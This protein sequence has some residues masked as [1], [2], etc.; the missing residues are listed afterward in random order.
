[1]MTITPKVTQ[2]CDQ[3][4]DRETP[5]TPEQRALVETVAQAWTEDHPKM[6][7]II[8]N[9]TAGSGKTTTA[10][11]LYKVLQLLRKELNLKDTYKS[12]Q[13]LAFNAAARDNFLEKGMTK[14]TAKTINGLG[15][16]ALWSFAKSR[17]LRLELDKF[18]QNNLMKEVDRAQNEELPKDQKIFKHKIAPIRTFTR[19]LIQFAKYEAIFGQGVCRKELEKV[20]NHYGLHLVWT[21]ID[22]SRYNLTKDEALDLSYAWVIGCLNKTLEIPTEGV[23]KVDFNDQVYLPVAHDINCWKNHLIVVDEAQDLSVVNKKLITKCLQPRGVLLMI[24]D[25]RQAIY[26]WRGC[27]PNQLANALRKNPQTIETPL[28]V[29]WRSGEEI[30]ELAREFDPRI[31]C[32]RKSNAIVD[33]MI[34]DEFA[35]NTLETVEGTA[36]LSRTRAPL[37][38]HALDCLKF[39]IPFSFK[40]DLHDVKETVNHVSKEDLNMPLAE[41][42]KAFVSYTDQVVKECQEKDDET[43]IEAARDMLQIVMTIVERL[44]LS[45]PRTVADIF[46]EIKVIEGESRESGGICLTT[47]HSAK[48]LEWDHVYLLGYEKIGCY[49]KKDWQHEEA[50]NLKFVALTRAENHLTFLNE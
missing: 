45:A 5:P 29:N 27:R 9:S 24:G 3:V 33:D 8:G 42:C 41:F 47:I 4:F 39:G 17:G 26:C 23:W 46:E 50:D 30:L 37:I 38:Q 36:L 10:G 1:M 16:S 43:A 15:A 44:D 14:K 20:A 49:A 19:K 18:H 7:V 12:I 13:F 6:Q 32:G 21:D 11:D 31:V 2:I 25:D 40:I 48:G 35:V 28:T 22:A 34:A